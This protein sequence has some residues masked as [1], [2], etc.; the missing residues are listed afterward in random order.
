MAQMRSVSRAM[1]IGLALLMVIFA[2]SGDWVDP[3][4]A[5]AATRVASNPSSLQVV[6]KDLPKSLQA[7]VTVTGPHHYDHLVATT[8]TLR[9]LVP[10]T[11]RVTA[12]PVSSAAGTYHPVTALQNVRVRTARSSSATVDYGDLVPKTTRP[13][14][15]TGTV[16][17][18]GP[19]TGQ[20]VLT[21]SGPAAS[22]VAVGQI[23]ASGSTATAPDGY[24]VKVTGVESSSAGTTVVDVEPAT[25]ME[26]LPEGALNVTATLSPATASQLV[27]MGRQPMYHKDFSDQYFTCSTSANFSVDPSFDFEPSISLHVRW[28]FFKVDSASFTVSVKEDAGLSA[29]ADAGATCSTK[30]DGIAL[31]SDVPLANIPFDVG[32]IPGDIEATLGADL[33][34]QATADAQV[35]AGV[36]QTATASAGV[37]YANGSFSPQSGFSYSFSQS[38]NAV[39]DASADAWVTPYVDLLLDGLAGPDVDVGG[40]LEF[41][42]A[43]N[44]DPWWTLQGCLKAGVGFTIDILGWTKSWSD[45]SLF[46]HCKALLSANGPFGGTT[47]TTNAA[48]TTTTVAAS[49]GA[50]GGGAVGG[51]PT[52]TS[53]STTT[54]PT[55]LV[56]SM[57]SPGWTLTAT[58]PPFPDMSMF[59][60]SC[61]AAGDCGAVGDNDS[62]R[63]I[64]ELSGGTWSPTS[65]PVPT[66]AASN[67]DVHLSS[68]NCPSAGNCVV[69]GDYGNDTAQLGLLDTLS[70]GGWSATAAPLA[71]GAATNPV[72]RLN[73][74]SCAADGDCVAVG[75]Y[76]DT[77]G[78]T[79]GVLEALSGGSWSAT[80]APLPTGA[81]ADPGVQL[82]AVS[83]AADGGCAAVGTYTD[84]AGNTQGL[85]EVLSGGSWSA[86]EAP[87]PPDAGTDPEVEFF[88]TVS[89]TTGSYCA[90]GGSYSP[91]GGLLEVLSNGSWSVTGVG[92]SP[93]TETIPSVSCAAVGSC[94]AVGDDIYGSEGN[95]AGTLL[96]LSDGTWTET[97]AALPVDNYTGTSPAL[98]SVVCPDVG[99]CVAVGTFEGTEGFYAGV[100]EVLSDGD[101]SVVATIDAG[102]NP[103]YYDNW[104]LATVSCANASSCAAIGGT[105]DPLGQPG[106]VLAV[107]SGS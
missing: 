86:T 69:V 76:S 98:S 82:D 17:I 97:D 96:V 13:V 94:V 57:G 41:N 6:V 74:V 53:T 30:G 63:L 75:T 99:S 80:E 44:Q 92:G 73:A 95:T 28:G 85:L 49:G 104:D 90:A 54:T 26:A 35:S 89:C 4:P 55:N 87:L 7:E 58:E 79:Q 20:R 3:A 77:A 27:R 43:T 12:R 72:V 52:T 18:T 60:V 23:L 33:S 29:D 36:Q 101:W 9:K 24:L 102:G 103:A 15:A 1:G 34:G 83:C 62:E 71:T 39:G 14:P 40:G 105:P 21:L 46:E 16:S 45:P 100:V 93:S 42:A 51:A 22:T 2:V 64:E 81:E 84:S 65:A 61:G 68:V 91:G 106:N 59:S 88:K 48:T 66:D 50:G 11:Y 56:P 47:T 78:D 19:A 10:G 32:G 5:V 107:L 25:L 31:L 67:A 37:T 38:F 8:L 70:G